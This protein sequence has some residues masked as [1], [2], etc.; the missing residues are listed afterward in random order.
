MLWICS[1]RLEGYPGGLVLLVVERDAGKASEP[2]SLIYS[3]KG[4]TEISHLGYVDCFV[5]SV[6]NGSS[7]FEAEQQMRGREKE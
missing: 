3:S 6:G 2:E 4:K 7:F 5:E 1:V